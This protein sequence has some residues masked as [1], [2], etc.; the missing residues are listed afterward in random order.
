MGNSAAH[1]RISPVDGLE[2]A[3]IAES[4][5]IKLERETTLYAGRGKKWGIDEDRELGIR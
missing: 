1:L 3:G 2:S 5:K 4:V